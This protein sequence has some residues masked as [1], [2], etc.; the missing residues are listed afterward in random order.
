[1]RIE[2]VVAL[3]TGAVTPARKTAMHR[4][5]A[6]SASDEHRWARSDER[7]GYTKGWW[8]GQVYDRRRVH[9]ARPVH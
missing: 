8:K 9:T 5:L 7:S 4:A 2:G 1:M 6:G 3:V